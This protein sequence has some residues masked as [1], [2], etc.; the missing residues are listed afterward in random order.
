MSL[1]FLGGGHP[2]EPR[3]SAKLPGTTI[4]RA[5]VRRPELDPPSYVWLHDSEPIDES[6]SW[7]LQ[8]EETQGLGEVLFRDQ[9]LEFCGVHKTL[10]GAAKHLE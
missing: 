8:A 6:T 10:E 7:T 1:R 5:A 2:R 3:D 9:V 4:A